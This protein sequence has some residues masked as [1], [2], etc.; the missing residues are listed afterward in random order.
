MRLLYGGFCVKSAPGR[1]CEYDAAVDEFFCAYGMCPNQCHFF[2]NLSYYYDKFLD[3]KKTYLHNIEN[4]HRIMAE[5]ELYKLKYIILHKIEPELKELKTELE[6]K[7]S[8]KLLEIHNDLSYIINNLS[9]VEED[10]EKWK[11]LNSN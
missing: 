4:G 11:N 2:F 3:L 8:E 7:G 1:V 5:K 10:I 6:L 9:V